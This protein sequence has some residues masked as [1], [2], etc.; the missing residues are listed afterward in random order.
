MACRSTFCL[1]FETIERGVD[2]RVGAVSA[3]AAY[4]A[5][6]DSSPISGCTPRLRHAFGLFGIAHQGRHLVAAAQQR[7]HAPPSR[8][9]QL[10]R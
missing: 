9:T 6:L 4:D 3:A 5:G 10:P 1:R 7:V 8:C 2:D